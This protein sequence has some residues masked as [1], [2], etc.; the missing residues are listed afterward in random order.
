MNGMTFRVE[1]ILGDEEERLALVEQC[2]EHIRMFREHVSDEFNKVIADYTD[3]GDASKL[4]KIIEI[5][6]AMRFDDPDRI[7]NDETYIEDFEE[8][9]ND[10]EVA[11]VCIILMERVF[12]RDF[13]KMM[14][15]NAKEPL[16]KLDAFNSSAFFLPGYLVGNDDL[17]SVQSFLQPLVF[18][19]GGAGFDELAWGK[20]ISPQSIEKYFRGD[21]KD[22][23]F[24][25]CGEILMSFGR[26][27][28]LEDRHRVIFDPTGMQNSDATWYF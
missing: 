5:G 26:L 17:S 12:S 19:A 18:G 1:E 2:R 9:S 24:D 6:K 14:I 3:K 13:I 20:E 11:T 28:R 23:R 8:L 16:K 25:G 22:S 27:C 15:K 10:M 21:S 4:M 7:I